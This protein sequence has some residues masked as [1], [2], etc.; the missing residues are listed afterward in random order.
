MSTEVT[1]HIEYD[2]LVPVLQ[3]GC[4][5][6]VTYEEFIKN[7]SLGGF[8]IC[9]AVLNC[10]EDMGDF[11][12]V[13]TD[14]A[15]TFND[16]Y[17]SISN[18]T[19]DYQVTKQALLNNYSDAESDVMAKIVVTGGD[20]SGASLNGTPLYVGQVINMTDIFSI[21]YDAKDTDAA[22]QQAIEI[23][24]YDENNIKAV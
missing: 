9:R 22:Y 17:I 6:Y 3:D 4:V 21:E 23:E 18:R 10:W 8:S 7:I 19:Q 12:E 13:V 15:P 5:K 16:L 11:G 2:D 24:V 14:T 1:D 20:L